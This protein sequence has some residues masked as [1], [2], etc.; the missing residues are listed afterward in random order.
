M[1]DFTA[2]E[3]E[4]RDAASSLSPDI[5]L[6]FKKMFGGLGAWTRGRM[7][8]AVTGFG[9]GLKLPDSEIE[10]LLKQ[11][12]RILEYEV[13]M[14]M[15]SYVV[16]PDDILKDPAQYRKLVERSITYCMDL[17]LKRKRKK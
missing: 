8:L 15:K 12:G 4:I 14:P 5:D 13:G 10:V 17:P 2:V 11:G 16:P 3:M 6:H 7:F 1:T 9:V